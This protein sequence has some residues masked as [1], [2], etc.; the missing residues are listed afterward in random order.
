[1]TVSG[2][3]FRLALGHFLT[4]VTVVTSGDQTTGPS[5]TTASSFS[6]VSLDPPLVSVCFGH[7]SDTLAVIRQVNRFGVN[8]LSET[9][10]DIA[11]KF[12]AR[13]DTKNDGIDWS[14]GAD[15]LPLLPDC[16]IRIEC[17]LHSDIEAGDHTILVG[18]VQGLSIIGKDA[19]RPLLYY[20][21]VL[22]D[23]DGFSG[24]FPE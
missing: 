22:S 4:G 17:R 24:L 21:G 15:E 16:L 20:R 7:L 11:L 5:G 1:M 6:S 23:L 14:Y 10:A 18:E 3:D 13:T 19:S 12:A 8:I 2:D 9:Q